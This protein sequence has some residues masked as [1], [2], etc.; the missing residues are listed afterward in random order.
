VGKGDLRI[1][2]ADGRLVMDSAHST[3]NVG[4][5]RM[6]DGKLTITE[7]GIDYP[8]DI[9]ELTADRLRIRMHSPGE[10]VE[11]LLTPAPS[12]AFSGTVR[13][14]DLE[15]G[16]WLIEADDGTRYQPL[17]LVEAFRKDGLRVK[18]DALRR[19]NMM[20]IGM[21]GPMIEVLSISAN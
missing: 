21:S 13:F 18:G 11:M 7:D 10:P 3:R 16:L 2:L 4:S 12:M 6:T 17:E 15:G 5:W 19:D 1:F 9:L 20:S 8:T 14:V